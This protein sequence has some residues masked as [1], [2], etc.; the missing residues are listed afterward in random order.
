MKKLI[1]VVLLMAMALGF[2]ACDEQVDPNAIAKVDDKY[3]T[4]VADMVAAVDPSG[5]TQIT[6]L[7]DV[8]I[9]ETIKLPYSCT[10]DLDG[11]TLATNPKSPGTGPKSIPW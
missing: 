1:A 9:Q 11:H 2:A 4:T 5:N 8:E 7:K 10:I 6:L 3:V